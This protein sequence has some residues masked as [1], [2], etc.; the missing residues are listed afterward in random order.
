[1]KLMRMGVGVGV[2]MM[3]VVV[4]SSYTIGVMVLESSWALFGRLLV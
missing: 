3:V 4:G 1:M 2:V